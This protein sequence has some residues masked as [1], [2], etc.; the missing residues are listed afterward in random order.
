MQR[1]TRVR[2]RQLILVLQLELLERVPTSWSPILV[3]LAPPGE[4]DNAISW[5]L[6]VLWIPSY[7]IFAH[8]GPYGAWLRRILE[9]T[10]SLGGSIGDKE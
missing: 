6:P 9:V 10:Q 7:V 8:N 4:Y 3:R 2:K 5:V 1:V